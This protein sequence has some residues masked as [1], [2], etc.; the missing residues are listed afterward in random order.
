[1]EVVGFIGNVVGAEAVATVG[2][3]HAIERAA[4]CRHIEHLLK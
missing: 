2:H 3:R 1:M 4:L